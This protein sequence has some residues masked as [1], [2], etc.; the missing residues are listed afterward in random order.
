MSAKPRDTN[1]LA[2]KS[3]SGMLRETESLW[4]GTT[5]MHHSSTNLFL[6]KEKGTKVKFTF[7]MVDLIMDVMG[8]DECGD[9]TTVCGFY[10]AVSVELVTVE[11]K[12]K[13]TLRPLDIHGKQNRHETST[14]TNEPRFT[15]EVSSQNRNGVT[16]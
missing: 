4:V 15:R 14:E 8:Q 7:C 9:S 10:N 16:N 6:E 3:L 5:E 12:H 11:E 1:P 2:S 13:S